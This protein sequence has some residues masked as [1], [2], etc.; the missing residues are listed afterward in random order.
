MFCLTKKNSPPPQKKKTNIYPANGSLIIS[1][2]VLSLILEALL[3]TIWDP[4]GPNNSSFKFFLNDF[5]INVEI[6][7]IK[8]QKYGIRVILIDFPLI[9]LINISKFPQLNFGTS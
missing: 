8:L 6:L 9:Y 5:F 2:N 1:D 7:L 4:L 3:I